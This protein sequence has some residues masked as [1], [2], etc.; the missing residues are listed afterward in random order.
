MRQ[1]TMSLHRLPPSELLGTLV[2]LNFRR[3]CSRRNSVKSPICLRFNTNASFANVSSRQSITRLFYKLPFRKSFLALCKA[4]V[5][6]AMAVFTDAAFTCYQNCRKSVPP[7]LCDSAIAEFIAK[8]IQRRHIRKSS[9]IFVIA[10]HF[11]QMLGLD[12][13]LDVFAMRISVKERLFLSLKNGMNSLHSHYARFPRATLDKLTESGMN[14]LYS[15]ELHGADRL[16][17]WAGAAD[18]SRSCYTVIHSAGT[19]EIQWGK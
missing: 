6:K 4:N 18:C 13:S 16:S 10:A 8:S 9:Q 5:A 11:L 12:T 15:F 19:L 2:K 1:R 7:G 3:K 14:L 17:A